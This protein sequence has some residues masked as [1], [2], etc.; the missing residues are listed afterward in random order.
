MD[1]RRSVEHIA[2]LLKSL[3]NR[4]EFFLTNGVVELRVSELTRIV[5]YCGAILT[6]SCSKLEI[7]G[8]SEDVK[9][10]VMVGITK[11]CVSSEYGFNLIK[12]LLALWRPLYVFLADLGS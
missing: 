10:L 7:A 3:D 1:V 9:I 12:G 2:V 6:D 8:I 5:R 4:K 11:E